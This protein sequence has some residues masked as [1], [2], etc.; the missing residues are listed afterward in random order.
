MSIKALKPY[1]PSTRGTQLVDYSSLWKGSPEKTL[2][3]GKKSCAG[4]N[5]QGRITVRHQGGGHKRKF[6][7]IDF[8]RRYDGVKCTVE[9]LEYDPNRTAFI[10]LVS[11]E[12]GK[13]S[14]IVAPHGVK[15]GDELYSGPDVDI[16]TGSTLP[17]ENIPVGSVVHNIELKPGGGAKL[18]R[19]AGVSARIAGRDGIYTVISLPSGEKRLI[20]SKSRATLG[21]VSNLDNKNIKIGKAGRSRWLGVRPSVRGV[22]MNPVD[23]PHGGG[24]GKSSGGRHPVTPWGVCTK[25]KKTRSRKKYSNFYIKSRG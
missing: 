8:N 5:S 23:H 12:D 4:R 11:Y 7:I 9:R 17:L 3:V 24:E 10:A 14:Y 25:G 19:A 18:V 22:A 15:K 2:V 1:T 20:P 13:K 6:R 21:V 16:L